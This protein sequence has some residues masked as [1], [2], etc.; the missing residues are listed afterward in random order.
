MS[1][2]IAVRVRFHFCVADIC[3][4]IGIGIVALVDCVFVPFEFVCV[5]L[6]AAMF[7]IGVTAIDVFDLCLM[8]LPVFFL[9]S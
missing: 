9:C 5:G 6:P 1:L 2:V 3:I 8:C 4:G 7:V